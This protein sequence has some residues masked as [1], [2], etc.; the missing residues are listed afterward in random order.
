MDG[1]AHLPCWSGFLSRCRMT[2][3]FSH[4]EQ[5][6]GGPNE[7]RTSRHHSTDC[8]E[9]L[10]IASC[11]IRQR[12]QRGEFLLTIAL[13]GYHGLLPA[14]VSL[15]HETRGREESRDHSLLSS[16]SFPFITLTLWPRPRPR[17]PPSRRA[18]PPGSAITPSAGRGAV[19]RP[20]ISFHSSLHRLD[21]PH[22]RPWDH[23]SEKRTIEFGPNHHRARDTKSGGRRRLCRPSAVRLPNRHYYRNK[24][25][26]ASEGARG[27]A[28]RAAPHEQETSKIGLND[29]RWPRLARWSGGRSVDRPESPRQIDFCLGQETAAVEGREEG[30]NDQAMQPPARPTAPALTSR[31]RAPSFPPTRVLSSNCQRR[32]R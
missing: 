16:P 25:A 5:T 26:T 10:S 20:F 12:R 30:E 2:S 4:A 19:Q 31:T 9:R 18:M 22:F 32:R 6:K 14:S 3:W 8:P 24:G 21:S 7:E 13:R 17:P 27:R 1:A 11:P 15:S 23:Q 29:G 28:G